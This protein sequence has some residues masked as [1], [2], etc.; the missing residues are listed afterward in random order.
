MQKLPTWELLLLSC[1]NGIIC[2]HSLELPRMLT[3]NLSLLRHTPQQ[4]PAIS[5]KKNQQYG[6]I[7][8]SLIIFPCQIPSPILQL[9]TWTINLAK[10]TEIAL[11]QWISRTENRSTRTTF[12]IMPM[13]LMCSFLTSMNNRHS[14]TS[15][16]LSNSSLQN[17]I[18]GQPSGM[19]AFQL[20]PQQ[21][22]YLELNL[23]VNVEG[24]GTRHLVHI[25]RL[26]LQLLLHLSLMISMLQTQTTL[27]PL[28]INNNPVLVALVY[29]DCFP[30][31]PLEL[32]INLE[33]ELI[34]LNCSIVGQHLN[35]EPVS[36]IRKRTTTTMS[37]QQIRPSSPQTPPRVAQLKILGKKLEALFPEDKEYL[38]TVQYETMVS[39]SVQ[40]G[41][42]DAAS[43]APDTNGRNVVLG[44]FVD[45]RGVPPR[46]TE[47]SERLIHVF[48]D[49]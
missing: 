9:P 30:S 44:S 31:P 41:H 40:S 18:V 15:M 1:G 3:Q 12:T 48:V 45:T 32:L 35:C 17:V 47:S 6:H 37:L 13:N 24:N 5:E 11:G 19:L 38:R 20:R 36:Y 39:P 16:K 46:K 43:P 42:S 23:V 10:P 7:D 25:L 22:C 14:V 26:V 29:R 2:S 21:L 49:Q 28:L 8:L 33:V 34:R 27:L 4:P